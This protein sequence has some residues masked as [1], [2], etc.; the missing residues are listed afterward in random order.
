VPGPRAHLHRARRAR[1]E[2]PARYVSGYLMMDDR[3]EQDA[4][5]AWAEAWVSD[6]LGWVGF[7]ISNGISAPIRVM[8]AWPR[9][10]DY[11]DAAPPITGISMGAHTE[12]LSVDLAVEHRGMEQ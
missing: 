1:Q 10:S 4:T 6:G 11:R 7:D 9:G 8:S 12:D 2:I 5:H 3:V